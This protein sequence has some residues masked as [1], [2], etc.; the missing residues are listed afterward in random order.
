M[1]VPNE[2]AAGVG[3]TSDYSKALRLE[4]SDVFR[5]PSHPH[6]TTHYLQMP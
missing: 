2:K 6:A 1:S 3:A 4:S 5:R